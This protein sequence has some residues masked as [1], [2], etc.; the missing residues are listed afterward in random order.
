MPRYAPELAASVIDQYL[1]TDKPVAL[2]ARDHAIDERDVTRI[3]HAASLPPR[4]TRMRSL[5][6]AMAG[7]VE[8]RALLRASAADVDDVGRNKHAAAKAG[9]TRSAPSDEEDAM[10]HSASKTR[11]NALEAYCALPAGPPL[12]PSDASA[13]D[14]IERL[15]EQEL[16]AEEAG[17][18][19]LG[20]LPR[21]PGEAERCART[22][23]ILTRTLH[24]L[25]QLRGG[26]TQHG[27]HHDDDNPADI[28]EFRRDLARR[29][30]AFVASRTNGRI[31]GGDSRAAPLDEAT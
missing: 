13:I 6:P 15:V 28:D 2:I 17:R 8:A 12:P 27:P 11:V 22:L 7:L 16:A 4:R 29:I 9:A 23:A 25:A 5:P 31:A 21:A 24:A 30:D 19:E 10:R 18:A 1:H 3:R 14:R 26:A 20:L